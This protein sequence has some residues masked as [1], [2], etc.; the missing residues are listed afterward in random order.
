MTAREIV[1]GDKTLRMA[2]A[3]VGDGEADALAAGGGQQHVVTLGADLHVDDRLVAEVQPPQAGAGEELVAMKD[4]G[5]GHVT[6]TV[7][8]NRKGDKMYLAPDNRVK[9][10]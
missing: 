10:W 2:H 8:F 9:I 1:V 4:F 3:H 7:L 6:R 5:K